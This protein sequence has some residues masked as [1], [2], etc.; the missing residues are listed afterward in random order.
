MTFTGY[1]YKITGAC[2]LVYIGSSTNIWRRK[3][4]HTYGNSS[5]SELLK[6]PLQFEIIDTRDYKLIKTLRLV[7]QFYIDNN[8][9]VNHHRA[10]I[11]KKSIN[12][13]LDQKEKRR[14]KCRKYYQN[15]RDKERE[16]LRIYNENNKEKVRER[17]K[18]YRD[19]NKEKVREC[20]RLNYQNNKDTILE[21]H[22]IY[23]EKN[24]EK[25]N[26][27][28]KCECGCLI[29][30]KSLSRHKKTKKHINLLTSQK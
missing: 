13:I 2:G 18:K 24:K 19:N 5:K 27:K 1:I 16:R 20:Q 8:N 30:N 23:N 29:S 7:E 14:E 17:T 22:R 15:N 21:R 25:I 11:N 26:R 6:K 4:S 3:I 12:Y 10:Y 28:V 9:T